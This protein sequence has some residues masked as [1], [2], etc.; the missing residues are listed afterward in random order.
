MQFEYNQY[1]NSTF[2]PCCVSNYRTELERN[3]NKR[4]FEDFLVFLLVDFI[5]GKIFLKF[6]FSQHYK[7]R[8]SRFGT[9]DTS[10]K[11]KY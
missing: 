10:K 7:I 5:F 8:H 3:N 11:S 9:L 6:M 4:N 1:K 2:F